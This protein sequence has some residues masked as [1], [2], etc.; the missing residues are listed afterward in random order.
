MV[1]VFVALSSWMMLLL[2]LVLKVMVLPRVISYVLLLHLDLLPVV[3]SIHSAAAVA[4]VAVL[5]LF[6]SRIVALART[7]L[8]VLLAWEAQSRS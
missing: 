7:L 2:T 3:A 4:V 8:V 1:L 6:H 5:V